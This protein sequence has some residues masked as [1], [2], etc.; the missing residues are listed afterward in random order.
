MNLLGNFIERKFKIKWRHRFERP[1]FKTMKTYMTQDCEIRLLGSHTREHPI[2]LETPVEE[3]IQQHWWNNEGENLLGEN[4]DFKN[5]DWS[6]IQDK[7]ND[8]EI[9]VKQHMFFDC[10]EI[11]NPEDYL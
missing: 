9:P 10:F 7:A 1:M 2:R 4:V 6:R 3:R 11:I 8:L 5:D